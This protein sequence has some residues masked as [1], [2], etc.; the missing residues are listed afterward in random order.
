MLSIKEIL[1]K[2]ASAAEPKTAAAIAATL[3]AADKAI[4]YD[5]LIISR[6]GLNNLYEKTIIGEDEVAVLKNPEKQFF[7]LF[8]QSESVLSDV[9]GTRD[10]KVYISLYALLGVLKQSPMAAFADVVANDPKLAAIL[11]PG[12]A[13][14]VCAEVAAAGDYI[15]PF[16]KEGNHSTLKTDKVLH[17]VISLSSSPAAKAAMA[18]QAEK[19]AQF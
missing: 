6:V 19:L 15:N 1:A 8:I 5:N 3:V 17:H 2:K 11:L 9:D 18:A 13:I 16:G 7:T 14:T 10:N 12:A 4:I